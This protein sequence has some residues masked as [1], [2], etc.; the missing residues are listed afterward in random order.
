M[1]MDM[2]CK[3]RT[4][5]DKYSRNVDSCCCHQKSRYILVAVRHHNK[6]IKLVCH[7]HGFC[8]I[9]DQISGN[10]GIF[11]SDMSHCNTI[12][13]CNSREN[14]RCTTSHGNTLFYSCYYFIQIHMTWHDFVIGTYNTYQRTFHLFFCKAKSIK[15]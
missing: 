5:A 9:C 7:R 11:H 3:H 10:K 15:Q 6:G 1:S 13:Y 2:S 14:D 8:G 12:T 4:T